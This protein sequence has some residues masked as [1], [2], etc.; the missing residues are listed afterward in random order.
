VSSSAQTLLVYGLIVCGQLAK[1]ALACSMSHKYLA[2]LALPTLLNTAPPRCRIV[3]GQRLTT[4]GV[5]LGMVGRPTRWLRH[6]SLD[7][8]FIPSCGVAFPATPFQKSRIPQQQSG[9]PH[10]SPRSRSLLATVAGKS[11]ALPNNLDVAVLAWGGSA[12]CTTNYWKS[13]YPPIGA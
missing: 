8:P 2:D 6:R 7:R 13:G 10:H 4:R 1:S 12:C 9:N 11:A 5:R 3:V